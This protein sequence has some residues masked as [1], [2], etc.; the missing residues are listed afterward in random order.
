MNEPELT[1][2]LRLER[3]NQFI[4]RLG[5]VISDDIKVRVEVDSVIVQHQSA[6]SQMFFIANGAEKDMALRILDQIQVLYADLNSEYW[7]QLGQ[8]RLE[9]RVVST[10]DGLE[11]EFRLPQP[12]RSALNSKNPPNW[13]AFTF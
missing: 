5:A 4:D 1:L 13:G 6:Y 9:Y 3:L 7:P 2:A 8:A 10:A 12:L 11:L